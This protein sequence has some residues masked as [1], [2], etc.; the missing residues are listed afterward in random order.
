[1]DDQ[2]GGEGTDHDGAGE[3]L[4]FHLFS[5]CDTGIQDQKAHCNLN[6]LEGIGNNRNF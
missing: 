4:R 1:M 3:H 6:S 2:H 5:H